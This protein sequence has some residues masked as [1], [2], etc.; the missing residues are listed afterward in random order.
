MSGFIPDLR[1]FHG[2][3]TPSHITKMVGQILYHV[4][5]EQKRHAATKF[6]IEFQSKLYA[7]QSP[8]TVYW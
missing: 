8:I 6:M 7:L 2:L 5:V 1:P 4:L 3:G